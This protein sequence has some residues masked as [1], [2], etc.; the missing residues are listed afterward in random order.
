MV[1]DVCHGVD[2]NSAKGQ[3]IEAGVAYTLRAAILGDTACTLLRIASYVSIR[4]VVGDGAPSSA[5]S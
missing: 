2:A 5:V 3:V 4:L 1:H